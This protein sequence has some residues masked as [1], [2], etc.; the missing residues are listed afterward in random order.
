[1]NPFAQA[2]RHVTKTEGTATICQSAQD[3]SENEEQFTGDRN[4]ESALFVAK[5]T[6]GIRKSIS[7]IKTACCSTPLPTGG[8]NL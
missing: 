4:T 7:T 1:M 6:S 3:L 5:M 8:Y 2:R